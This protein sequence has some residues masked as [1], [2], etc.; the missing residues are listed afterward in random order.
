MS[1]SKSP[2]SFKSKVVVG[3]G[4]CSRD[5]CSSKSLVNAFKIVVM[6]SIQMDRLEDHSED[7]EN[8]LSRVLKITKK[9]FYGSFKSK[10]T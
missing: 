10:S 2:S 6:P 8:N 3:H 4:A 7:H 9:D 1:S 5:I